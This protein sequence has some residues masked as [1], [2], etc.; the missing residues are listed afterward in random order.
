MR[1]PHGGLLSSHFPCVCV[2]VCAGREGVRTPLRK[3]CLR[4]W[5]EI[6]IKRKKTKRFLSFYSPAAGLPRRLHA[7]H[8]APGLSYSYRS[9]CNSCEVIVMCPHPQFVLPRR[10]LHPPLDGSRPEMVC[11]RSTICALITSPGLHS[12]PGT[13]A[14]PNQSGRGL[15]EPQA[16]HPRQYLSAINL[17]LLEATVS[18]R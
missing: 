4:C 18:P 8:D 1:P 9:N 7:M 17:E 11:L 16:A 15:G 2:C 3:Q 10:R 6:R 14:V 5:F 13:S 12:K